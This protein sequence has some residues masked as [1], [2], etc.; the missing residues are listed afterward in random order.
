MGERIIGAHAPI[1]PGDRDFLNNQ[2]GYSSRSPVRFVRDYFT[3]DFSYQEVDRF[4]T[5]HEEEA[6]RISMAKVVADE[7][8]LIARSAIPDLTDPYNYSHDD[9]MR[10]IALKTA[11]TNE[12]D[13][14]INNSAPGFRTTPMISPFDNF[15]HLR[16]IARITGIP[17]KDLIECA[18][19]PMRFG[20]L[21]LQLFR[22]DGN[23]RFAQRAI[24]ASVH[25]NSYGR[26]LQVR[27]IVPNMERLK[28]EHRI[29][30][31]TPT[32]VA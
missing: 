12:R 8:F 5:T 31:V 11:I 18:G 20:S 16:H 17:S 10:V 4:F 22:N 15:L 27:K 28:D 25:G 3:G 32:I 7:F 29:Y 30:G 24:R 2:I 14:A 23:S 13:T 9:A 6:V 19:R 26:Q 21:Q 1:S